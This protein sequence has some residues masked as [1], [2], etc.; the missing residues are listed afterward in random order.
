MERFQHAL[1][2]RASSAVHLVETSGFVLDSSRSYAKLS[3]WLIR[4]D[5]ISPIA[6]SLGNPH[7]AGNTIAVLAFR[8]N[9]RLVDLA[10]PQGTPV[11]LRF[12]L[13]TALIEL[14][15]DRALRR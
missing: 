11:L 13:P 5:L 4:L 1:V 14:G 8:P 3:S 15:I 12:R 9:R 7:R 6:T 10:H 2:G